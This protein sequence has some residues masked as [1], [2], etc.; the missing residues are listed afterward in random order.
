MD[1]FGKNEKESGIY[2][3]LISLYF[4][5]RRELFFYIHDIFDIFNFKIAKGFSE[6]FTRMVPIPKIR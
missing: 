2:P 3:L 6:E 4:N 5:Q 1:L